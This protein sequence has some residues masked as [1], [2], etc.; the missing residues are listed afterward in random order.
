MGAGVFL[1]A[2]R[3]LVSAPPRF[4]LTLGMNNANKTVKMAA[5]RAMID[6]VLRCANLS[7]WFTQDLEE[8]HFIAPEASTPASASEPLSPV[9]PTG[10]QR[11]TPAQCR[12]IRTL[13]KIVG[14]AEREIIE[15]YGVARLED[16]SSPMAN[17]LVRRLMETRHGEAG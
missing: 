8:V 17:K 12:D 16:L 4:H 7:Q 5:K 11:C 2:E 6:G 1:V 9:L 10:E 15:H 14:R 13:L 3:V